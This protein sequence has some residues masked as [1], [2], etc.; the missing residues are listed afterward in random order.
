[1]W[2]AQGGPLRENFLPLILSCCFCSSSSYVLSFYLAATTSLDLSV[3]KYY[4]VNQIYPPP[5]L[6]P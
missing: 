3:A 2:W 1:M 6:I 5:D 4:L